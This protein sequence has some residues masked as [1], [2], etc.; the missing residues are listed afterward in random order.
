[1]N[2]KK[3]QVWVETVI[4]TLIGLV[5]ISIILSIALPQIDK[6]RDKNIL[7]QTVLAF[8]DIDLKI[9]QI[10][11]APGNLGIIEFRIAKGIF[12]INSTEDSLIYLLEDTSLKYG[13]ID[14]PIN[15]GGVEI[16]TKK[17]GNKFNIIVKK[18]YSS[19]FDITFEN[20][21]KIK[22]LQKGAIPYKIQIENLGK[23]PSDEKIHIDFRI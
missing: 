3:S 20:S 2:N 22:V 23:N 15:E 16:V 10:E 17:K 7:Y 13:E 5:I 18:N 1:M 4:Y 14:Y 19:S 11:Q 9:R 6:S 8:K 12:L 21:E